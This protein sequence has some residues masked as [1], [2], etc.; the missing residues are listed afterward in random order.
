MKAWI[1]IASL[2]VTGCTSGG[3]YDPLINDPPPIE[4]PPTNVEVQFVSDGA[5]LPGYLMLAGGQG[6]QP[7]V[8]LLHGYPGNEKNLDLAQTLR[9][10]GLHIMFIHYR[11]AWGA[12]GEFSF[13]NIHED[14]LAALTFLRA[15]ARQYRI[16][17]DRLIV[18]GHSM[19]GLAALRTVAADREVYC[20]VGLAAANFGGYASRS[21]EQKAAFARYSDQLFM[22]D[23]WSGAKAIA[24]IEQN[25]SDFD[26]GRLGPRL[27]ERAM[28]LVS[29]TEDSVVPLSVQRDLAARWGDDVPRL[30]AIEIPGDHSFAGQ[31]LAL[32]RHVVSWVQS[33]CLET[34]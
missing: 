31:R 1:A 32:Q 22:L 14:A 23:D 9:R 12:E 20:G 27:G 21:A 24:E 29:G 34:Q 28:L 13:L 10:A 30:T 19:G 26:L 3:R 17:A 25:A 8:L 16:D 6:A 2:I 18:I 4:P 33:A 11:G 15:H 7:T 5:R